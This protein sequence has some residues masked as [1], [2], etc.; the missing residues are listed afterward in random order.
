MDRFLLFTIL[1]FSMLAWQSSYNN[2]NMVLSS[3]ASG[4][5]VLRPGYMS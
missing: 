2:A 4:I 1:V 5:L 3:D